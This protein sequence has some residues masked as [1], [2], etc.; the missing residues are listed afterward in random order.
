MKDSH[1]RRLQEEVNVVPISAGHGRFRA[2]LSDR[3]FADREVEKGA[4]VMLALA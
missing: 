2:T 3:D 4:L 1:C